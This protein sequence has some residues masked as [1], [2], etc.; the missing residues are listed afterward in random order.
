ME[1]VTIMKKD[2]RQIEQEV[3][4]EMSSMLTDDKGMD[5]LV[6]QYIKISAQVTRKFLEKYE[7]ENERN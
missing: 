5:K 3:I 1:G 7:Q 6:T 4:E 2:L